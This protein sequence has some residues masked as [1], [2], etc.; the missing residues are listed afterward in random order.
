VAQR[1][2]AE[3]SSATGK[4]TEKRKRKEKKCPQLLDEDKRNPLTHIH[5]PQEKDSKG[6]GEQKET[7]QNRARQI[8]G[9]GEFH[10]K[11]EPRKSLI[12]NLSHGARK[13]SLKL[14]K[15]QFKR[16]SFFFTNSAE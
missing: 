16:K 11:S 1:R 4:H 13:N 5:T 10:I 6:K 12:Q 14:Y 9:L 2:S 7:Q 8:V 3:S 15:Q